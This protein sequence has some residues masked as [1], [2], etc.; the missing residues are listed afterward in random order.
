MRLTP[1]YVHVSQQIY[2]STNKSV[3]EVPVQKKKKESVISWGGG[4]LLTGGS[5][6]S[7]YAPEPNLSMFSTL[8]FTY[9]KTQY[10]HLGANFQR[11]SKS[12]IKISE[13][14]DQGVLPYVWY[15]GTC[16]PNW[17]V[18][19]KKSLNMGPIF[20]KKI[21]KKWVIFSALKI[22]KNGYVILKKFLVRNGYLF[23]E[24]LPL[25]MG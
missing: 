17:S 8:Y 20:H 25:K 11:N 3:T 9:F 18:F 1:R 4:V 13:D 12:G 5:S 23:S 21:L 7:G 19:P 14:Q 10:R 24:S 22:L 16:C 6:P 2:C 15:R